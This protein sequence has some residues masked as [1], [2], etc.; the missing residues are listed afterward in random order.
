VSF[1]T[2][3][4]EG[5]PRPKQRP[6]LLRNGRAYTPQ[7]T[8]D[9]ERMVR[10]SAT[11]AV[12]LYEARSGSKWPTTG[13]G[14]RVVVVIYT[15]RRGGST[16]GD[17]DNYAKSVLDGMSG[18]VRKGIVGPVC[19]D[20]SDVWNLHTVRLRTPAGCSSLAMVHV[21]VEDPPADADRW[22]RLFYGYAPATTASAT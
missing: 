7:E 2:F 19:D 18:R 12:R 1:L 8:V 6:R 17:V 21:Y 11:D 13:A 10:A 5:E 14:Y 3:T 16:R 20:D 22:C 15:H 4:V 9:Y